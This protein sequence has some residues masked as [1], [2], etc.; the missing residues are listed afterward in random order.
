ME[1]LK[2]TDVVI[3]GAGPTGLFAVFQLG[4]LGLKAV[5]IDALD[6]P[7]GQCAEL[8]PQKPIYDI[9]ALPVVSGQELT[10]QLIEQC[11]PFEPQLEL[12]QK[13]DM[14]QHGLDG[15]FVVGTSGGNR[16]SA[17]AVF[18]AAGAGCFVPRKPKLVELP[19]FEKHSIRYAVR[20]RNELA[21]ADIVIAG[22]GDSALDWVLDLAGIV[23][24][25][26]LVHR[27]AKFRAH[28]A[29]ANQVQQAIREGQI[30]F[31]EGDVASLGGENGR[32]RQVEIKTKTGTKTVDAQYLLPLFGLNIELGAIADWGLDLE[33]GRQLKVDTQKF[34]T[35]TPG[36]FAIGDI[37]WYPGKLKLILSG[38][39]EAALAAQGAFALARPEEKLRFQ[40]TTS[41]SE[42][43]KRLKVA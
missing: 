5:V 4:L 20:E 7:G 30:Q 2:K 32:L 25:L 36:I 1:E 9:P 16:F 33:A 14:L 28:P 18:I 15:R 37:N 35:S 38:F 42:L 19:D 31:V 24:T 11:A 39:H 10:D 21:G 23:G 43:Q 40:Y 12:G 29:T 13:V 3:I 8:Y 17:A 22:G 41:S 27:R 6:K 26:T 34:E